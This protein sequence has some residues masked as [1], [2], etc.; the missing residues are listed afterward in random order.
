[1]KKNATLELENQRLRERIHELSQQD[2]KL[3]EKE[4]QELSRSRLNLEKKFMK[5]VSMFVMIYMVQD[6]NMMNL[7]PFAWKLFTVIVAINR[8]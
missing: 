7:V 8:N 6:V 1:M 4:K 5:K 3:P 2:A